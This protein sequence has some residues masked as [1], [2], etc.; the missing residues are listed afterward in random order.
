MAP[1]CPQVILSLVRSFAEADTEV[2]RSFLWGPLGAEITPRTM[3]F[4][5]YNPENA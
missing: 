4:D 3:A 5:T 2:H 1:Q